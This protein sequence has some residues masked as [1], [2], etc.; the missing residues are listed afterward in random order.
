MKLVENGDINGI[1]VYEIFGENLLV[2]IVMFVYII[3][4]FE[5]CVVFF[6]YIC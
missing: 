6:V 5:M 1:K 4:K 2:K 3:V